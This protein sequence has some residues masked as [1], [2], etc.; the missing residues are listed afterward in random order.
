MKTSEF[1]AYY[2]TA[3]ES[4]VVESDLFNCAGYFWIN[5]TLSQHRKMYDLL[6]KQGNKEVSGGVSLRNGIKIN[7]I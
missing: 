7:S 6:I 5:L 4:N 3:I 1:N 2:R